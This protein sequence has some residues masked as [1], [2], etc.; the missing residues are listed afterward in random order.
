MQYMKTK[1]SKKIISALIRFP[2]FSR[3]VLAAVDFDDEFGLRTVEVDNV[4][5]DGPLTQE[6]A[7]F[8]LFHSDF[9]P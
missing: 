5:T 1:S 9:G 8:D 3:E 7:P 2:T 6:S 4:L